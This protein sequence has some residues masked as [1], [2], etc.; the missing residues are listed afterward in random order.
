MTL[1]RVDSWAPS[2]P[3]DFEA[4]LPQPQTARFIDFEF[5]QL[6]TARSEINRQKCL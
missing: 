3:R 2:A 4:V 1:S 6:E 5:S